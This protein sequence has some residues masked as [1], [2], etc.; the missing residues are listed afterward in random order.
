MGKH[1][2]SWE[3]QFYRMKSR[4]ERA[5]KRVEELEAVLKAK[6]AEPSSEELVQTSPNTW[7]YRSKT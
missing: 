2:D 4:A 7:E 3:Q 5:E 6:P 1:N